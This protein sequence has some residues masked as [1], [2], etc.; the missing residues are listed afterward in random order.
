MQSRKSGW[1][2]E[3]YIFTYFWTCPKHVQFTDMNY[4]LEKITEKVTNSMQ[5]NYP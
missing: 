1:L 3:L 5:L 4:R 2:L